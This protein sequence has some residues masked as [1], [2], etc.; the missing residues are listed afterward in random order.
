MA[1]VRGSAEGRRFSPR[2][3]ISLYKYVLG[4]LLCLLCWTSAT[5]AGILPARAVVD[6]H[7]RLEWLV[8]AVKTALAQV[9]ADRCGSEA[10]HPCGGRDFS[11]AAVST[12]LLSL[13][14]GETDKGGAR[15]PRAS[16]PRV[17][18]TG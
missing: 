15:Q 11:N 14:R 13:L 18:C 6:A 7:P 10:K 8:G 1:K 2:I 5:A 3:I 9:E 17:S 12:Y 16:T 4:P